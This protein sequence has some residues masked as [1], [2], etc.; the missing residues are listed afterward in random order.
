MHAVAGKANGVQKAWVDGRQVYNNGGVNF[1]TD[2][3]LI[4]NFMLQVFHGGK[5]DNPAFQPNR[6][7][8]IRCDPRM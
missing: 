6:R 3:T 8:F 2:D 5:P 7:Q 1:R 4:D